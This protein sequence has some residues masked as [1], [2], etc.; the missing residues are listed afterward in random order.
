[1]K[2][3]YRESRRGICHIQQGTLTE[4]VTSCVAIS[5]SN[6]LVRER[7]QV[8]YKGRKDEEEDVGSQW[9]YFRKR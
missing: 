8:E 1:M 3:H 2:A 4:F 5:F 7:W 6:S 9:M